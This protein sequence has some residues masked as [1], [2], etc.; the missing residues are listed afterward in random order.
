[1]DRRY[2]TICIIKA[3][4]GEAEIKAIVTKSSELIVRESGI[5]NT[6]DE[7]G[8]RRL[9]YP[10]Q[11][12]HDGYYVLFD[13]NSGPAASKELERSLKI[14]EDVVRQQTVKLDTE[15]VAPAPEPEKVEEPV[16]AAAPATEAAP[17]EKTEAPA[18]EET[19][20]KATEAPAEEKTETV[21]AETTKE[22]DKTEEG[23]ADG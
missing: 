11:K 19:P 20:A 12:K 13:Y 17:A 6:V 16:A 8:R 5:V 10:I 15:Y 14:N 4:I 2:E 18:K 3:D 22:T 9:A 23:G 1:M 7:W 21:E